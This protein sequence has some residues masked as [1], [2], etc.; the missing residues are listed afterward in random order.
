MDETQSPQ[1]ASRPHSMLGYLKSIG[2]AIIVAS[3]VLGPGSILTN[4][5]VGWQ[6]GYGL[7]WVLISACGLMMAMTALAM[8]VGVCLEESPC[9]TMARRGGRPVAVAVGICLFLVAAS[10]QF[11]N[12]L[13]V[14][15]AIEP[16]LE[17][18]EATGGLAT[19]VLV[20]LNALV[21][22][23][24]W[25]SR[26]LYQVVERG[27]KLLVGIMLLAF[28]ANLF[29]AKPSLSSTLQGLVPQFPQASGSQPAELVVVL[30]LVATTFSVAAAFYQAYLVQQRGWRPADLRTGSVDSVVGILTLGLMSLMIMVTAAAS[31]YGNPEVTELK[32]AADVARQLRPL[33]G[34]AAT[35]LFCM[36]IMAGALSSFLVNA[37]IGGCVL[38]DSLGLGSNIDQRAPRVATIASLLF[39]MSIA[40]GVKAYGLN[41]GNLIVFAQ[42]LTVLGNP[43]LAG[44]LLWLASLP[45]V[46]RSG[47][48]PKWLVGLGGLGFVVVLML[49]LRTLAQL[50]L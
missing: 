8:R 23:A 22:L 1:S 4:S 7:V 12:N 39:G 47:M 21:I 37:M 9:S 26:R 34:P 41:T 3:V 31:F 38:S 44:S 20:G 49:S 11:S 16:L 24:L 50:V 18:A 14:L 43:L 33:F 17:Q 46:R 29:L 2:P 6:Y 36:G 48:V 10:F 45:E 40:I 42:S 28:A 35:L 27:M 30:G 15:F 5:K 13:G 25:K 32:S 19:G